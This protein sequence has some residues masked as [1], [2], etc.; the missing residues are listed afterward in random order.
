[1]AKKSTRQR[2][3]H[4]LW[5]WLHSTGHRRIAAG[6]ALGIV[7]AVSLMALLPISKTAIDFRTVGA[8]SHAA[9]S[10]TFRDTRWYELGPDDWDPYKATLELR[11]IGESY[12]DDDPRAVALLKK[13]RDIWDNAP[14]NPLLDGKA[15]RIPG[16]VVPLEHGKSG[17]TEFL[18]VPYYGACIHSPPPPSNQILRALAPDG[19]QRLHTMDN[20]WVSGRLKV[21]RTDSSMGPSGYS[22]QVDAIEPYKREEGS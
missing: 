13:V 15:I 1:M 18:L 7:V 11:R 2:T 16:Y 12:R 6:V 14:T 9:R 10:A 19:I 17:M 4:A 20:V 3:A 21:S 5:P 22:L 8:W